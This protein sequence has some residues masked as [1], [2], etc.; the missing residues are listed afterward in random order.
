MGANA[1]RSDTI[2]GHMKSYKLPWISVCLLGLCACTL[3]KFNRPDVSVVSV[4]MLGGNILQQSFAVKLHV[5]NPNDRA[6]PIK[7]LHVALHVDGQE[8]ATGL[9]DHAFNVP[10]Y[11][12]TDFDMTIKANMASILG[13]LAERMN[14][15][16]DSIDYELSGG[17][18]ID[19]PLVPDVPFRQSG[20]FALK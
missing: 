4:D 7:G 14:Q 15:H 3:S 8:I 19:L 11:G 2:V 6:L 12:A 9:S 5:Q 17:A 13:K 18:S 10:A 1:Y 20:T 16:A